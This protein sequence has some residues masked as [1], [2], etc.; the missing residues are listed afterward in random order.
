M[1]A[2]SI[3][4][5]NPATLYASVNVH[6]LYR[7]EDRGDHWS[8]AD[9]TLPA[10]DW[11]RFLAMDP[12]STS[13][14]YV[15]V[16]VSP[17]TTFVST[18]AGQS[19]KDLHL[20]S[21]GALAIDPR[22]TSTLYAAAFFEVVKSIDGGATWTS[23]PGLPSFVAELAM[24]RA[25][26]DVLYTLGREPLAD[27]RFSVYKTANGGA[28]W[29][30]T[31]PL[32]GPPE[33]AA[34]NGVAVDPVSS[35]VYAASDQGVFRSSDGG[36]TWTSVLGGDF[37]VVAA[38]RS[39]E[40]Y[41]T[42]SH[43]GDVYQ[44]RDAGAHW[45]QL[46]VPDS[47]GATV[48]AGSPM[49]PQTVYAGLGFGGVARST[50]SGQT[51]SRSSRGIA[52]LN[53][54]P[55][56]DPAHPSDVYAG[57][58][59]GLFH[60]PDGGNSWPL[61]N[62]DPALTSVAVQPGSLDLFSTL[63]HSVDG[64]TTWEALALFAGAGVPAIAARAPQTMFAGNAFCFGLS[65]N[66]A[67]VVKSVDG[68]STWNLALDS[69]WSGCSSVVVSPD[70]SEVFA[71]VDGFAFKGT[72]ESRDGGASW[73][74]LDTSGWPDTGSFAMVLAIDPNDPNLIYAAEAGGIWASTV[75]GGH[76][77]DISAGL[78]SP[79]YLASPDPSLVVD[80]A[81]PTTLYVSTVG[82]VYRSLD[83]GAS[84]S[85]FSDG[86]PTG[87]AS[88]LVIDATGRFLHVAAGG[89]VYDYDI[90]V[91][92]GAS[93][94]A[95]CLL[96]GRFAAT[97][98]AVDPRTGRL[99]VG[100]ARSQTDRWG[101]FSLPGFTGDANFPEIVVKM[102]DATAIGEGFW[103]FHSGLTDLEYTLSVVDTVTGQQKSY[104]NDRSD[105]QALCGGADTGTFTGSPSTPAA[106][107][108]VAARA[109][110]SAGSIALLGRFTATLSAVDPR[111][112]RE[113]AGVPIP[114]DAKWGYFSLPDFTGDA[115]FPEVFVKMLDGTSLGGF[116]WLFH[117]GL[118]DLEYTLTVTDQTTGAQN[119]YRNDRSDPARLCGAADT[120]A[121]HD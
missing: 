121:F 16:G 39:S 69:G 85:P 103:V 59:A 91:A 72:S 81:S 6:G 102:A 75:G 18:D 83:R 90:A 70:G 115:S 4:P 22:Q 108:R 47:F 118:T 51:F 66:L 12:V 112:G 110:G 107:A 37:S 40:V 57:T 1:Y 52:G 24:D 38:L 41:A 25:H 42:K 10:H 97:V 68:G 34:V 106:G 93:A 79:A 33:G 19:W 23:T 13:T 14:I 88:G 60:S 73:A 67:E 32:P 95:L 77:R 120:R 89:G 45:V 62:P 7:T 26:P 3:D 94:N 105:P 63:G 43:S 55:A 117:T 8:P 109:S 36:A 2:L 49:E 74:A 111:T 28:I 31:A 99:E 56:M 78:P 48:F 82:G 30:P 54:L 71:R 87:A 80:P 53:P 119:V 21:V 114:K 15:S 65:P 92:C 44:S 50:D 27:S 76:W 29:A 5:K 64:G 86:L 61:A 58:E 100:T 9:Q 113:A 11:V 17:G 20:E 35:V 96:G 46:S 101:Y 116:F 98:Q 104:Q 84:W